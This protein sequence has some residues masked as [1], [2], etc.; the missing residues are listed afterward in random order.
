MIQLLLPLPVCCMRQPSTSQ[1]YLFFCCC[2]LDVHIVL[3]QP[4]TYPHCS[5][6]CYFTSYVI[7]SCH[8]LVMLRLHSLHPLTHSSPPPLRPTHPSIHSPLRP[9][10][11]SIHP[12]I[13]P[14]TTLPLHPLI[15]PSNPLSPHP[16]IRPPPPCMHAPIICIFINDI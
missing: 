3:H 5:M 10:H 9:T 4:P 6:L 12:L 14:S 16:L 11:Q 2:F 1:S 7:A 8:V 13:H 15:H